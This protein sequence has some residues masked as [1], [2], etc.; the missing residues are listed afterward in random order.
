MHEKNQNE[1]TDTPA[2]HAYF[3]QNPRAA[4]EQIEA[5]AADGGLTLNDYCKVLMSLDAVKAIC[6]QTVGVAL[7]I[8]EAET[9]GPHTLRNAEV[10]V[11]SIWQRHNDATHGLDRMA[12][13]I[14]RAVS[15]EVSSRLGNFLEK[16]K[17]ENSN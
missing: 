5:A 7:S 3:T 2:V 14:V 4:R 11:E 15:L 6:V 16:P 8:I 12:A 13:N 10:I 17:P 1:T 9:T